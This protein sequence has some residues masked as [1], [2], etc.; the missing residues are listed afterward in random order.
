M[1][2]IIVT[3]Y[4][5][6]GN[7]WLSWLLGD[8]LN[9]PVGGLYAAVPLATEGKNR[10]KHHHVYQLHLRPEWE[11]PHQKA[12]PNAYC[13]YVPMWS[14]D[15]YKV[16]HVVRD[17]RD[18]AVSIWHYWQLL[19]LQR[20]LDAMIECKA[21]VAVHYSWVK[22]IECWLKVGVPI[23]RYEDLHADAESTLTNLLDG[24]N[25]KYARQRV[26]EAIGRQSFS[27]KKAQ[28]EID[29]DGR[30]YHKGIHRR[31]LRKGVVGDWVNH[32]RPKQEEQAREAFS[33]TAA[34]LGYDL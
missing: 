4:P 14:E 3:G 13:L 27:K 1:A 8:V 17:P 12:V 29:G 18:V 31:N 24:W 15:E 23:V 7:T 22:H 33:E 21:P 6:S 5:K 16:C 26:T 28:I 11:G 30:V 25:I 32:F 10:P 34:K 2:E 19:S 20:A 9:C